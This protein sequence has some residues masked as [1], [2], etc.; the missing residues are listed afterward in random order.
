MEFKDSD[1]LCDYLSHK[2]RLT[3]LFFPDH[4]N[5]IISRYSNAYKDFWNFLQ[6]LQKWVQSRCSSEDSCLL[7][8]KRDRLNIRTVNYRLEDFLRHR[9]VDRHSSRALSRQ[10]FLCFHLIFDMYLDFLQKQKVSR[11]VKLKRDQAALPMAAFRSQLLDQLNTHRVVVVAGDTG[12]GKSTQVPQYLHFGE[13]DSYGQPVGKGYRRIAVTQPRRIACISL[14][15]RVSTEMLNE[16]G[17]KVAFQVHE[18]HWQTDC[19]LGLVKC[20][21]MA[22]PELRVVLMSATINVQ[23]FS[24]F[25]DNC[26]IIEAIMEPARAYAEQTK[27]WIILPLHSTLSAVDQEKVFHIAPD[28]VR[29]CVLSTNISETSLTIDGIRFVADSGK[30]KELSWDSSARL[31]RLK[32]FPISKA[33]ANQRKGRAGRTGPGVCFRFYSQEDYDQFEVCSPVS[34]FFLLHDWDHSSLSVSHPTS[35]S[36]RS[37]FQ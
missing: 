36:V 2:K 18:R 1:C 5:P 15:A 25:F 37:R 3:D 6:K 29:K 20:L 12:C 9:E 26:P 34:F 24:S 27:R 21:V 13:L 33:S 7:S 31:R 28:G 19:L 4:K 10:N 30:V 16:L 8:Q 35:L 17:S 32:E 11:I 22:R 14:A 23:L